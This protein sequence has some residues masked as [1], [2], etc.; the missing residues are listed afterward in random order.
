MADNDWRAGWKGAVADVA[1]GII[2][3]SIVTGLFSTLRAGG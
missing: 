2:G 1:G 3:V